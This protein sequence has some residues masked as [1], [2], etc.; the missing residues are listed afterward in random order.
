MYPPGKEGGSL[1]RERF[2]G[3]LA[4]LLGSRGGLRGALTALALLVAAAG[5]GVWLAVNA[6][7]VPRDL[8]DSSLVAQLFPAG[9]RGRVALLLEDPDSSAL[10]VKYV[11]ALGQALGQLEDPGAWSLQR[12]LAI[13][14]AAGQAGCR[15]Q[16][17][18]WQAEEQALAVRCQGGDAAGML[19]TLEGSGL[20]RPVSLLQ[21]DG[22]EIY[23]IL[24]GFSE[25]DL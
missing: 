7:Q 6:R 18:S 2:A 20:F 9:Q 11:D 16:G 15:V 23:T 4:R 14:E 1:R 17:F 8:L 3:L 21:P 5:V 19:A 22:Q 12:F 13:L 24:C 10:L 25:P